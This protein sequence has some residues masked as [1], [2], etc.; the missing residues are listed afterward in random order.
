MSGQDQLNRRFSQAFDDVEIFFAG[1][2]EDAIHALVL[3]SGNQQVRAFGHRNLP[4]IF[5]TANNS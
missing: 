1:N 5:S 4:A 2:A 3:K